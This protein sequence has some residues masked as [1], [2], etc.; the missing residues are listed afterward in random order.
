MG[1]NAA[2]FCT[3]TASIPDDHVEP[4]WRLLSPWGTE[5]ILRIWCARV[6]ENGSPLIAETVWSPDRGYHSYVRFNDGSWT[7]AQLRKAGNGIKML[8]GLRTALG[9]S[10]RGP[11]KGQV[12]SRRRCLEWWLAWKLDCAPTQRDLAEEMEVDDTDT[13][14]RRW[15]EGARLTWPPTQAELNEIDDIG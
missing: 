12:W 14:V 10:P 13:A 6:W 2:L 1:M 9:G 3:V 7:R 15:R 4:Y 11:R 5:K 8:S